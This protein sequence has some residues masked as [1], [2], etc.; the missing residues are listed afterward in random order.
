MSTP[1]NYYIGIA[2]GAI[3]KGDGNVSVSATTQ[4]TAVDVEVRLQIDNG[5]KKTG[6]LELD[7]EIM[8]RT[9]MNYIIGNGIAGGQKGTDLPVL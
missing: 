7:A 9:I 8:L 1:V 6:L 4:G 3:Q 2:R 5:T